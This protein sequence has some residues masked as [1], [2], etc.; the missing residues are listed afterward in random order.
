MIIIS[1]SVE[2]NDLQKNSARTPISKYEIV[3]GTLVAGTL[4]RPLLAG[5]AV[6][7]PDENH[8]VVRLT[9]FPNNPY[10][11]CKNHESLTEYTVFA[12][13]IKDSITHKTRFQNPI[14]SGKLLAHFKSHLEIH[15][16]LLNTS[17]FMNLFPRQ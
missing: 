11:L 4:I 1:K 9:M 5:F 16:P 8:Y 3:S 12:K 13:M 14:A 15:F 6:Q 10:Y 2:A 7:F 17:V